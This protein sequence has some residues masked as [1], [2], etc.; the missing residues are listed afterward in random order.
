MISFSQLSVSR[1]LGWL[2]GAAM[3]AML[4]LVAI[5]MVSERS[6][7]LQERP[8]GVM[9]EPVRLADA[10]SAS[11]APANARPGMAGPGLIEGCVVAPWMAAV[12]L[13]R[14]GALL[15]GIAP[16]QP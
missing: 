13:S 9:G 2:V 6:L 4:A 10:L 3:L 12:E 14:P 11:A 15:Q 1:R 7:I 5:I 8:T 16:H